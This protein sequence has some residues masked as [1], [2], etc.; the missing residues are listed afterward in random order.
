M[1]VPK[2]FDIDDTLTRAVWRFN[3]RPDLYMHDSWLTAMPEGEVLQRLLSQRTTESRLAQYMLTRLG[4]AESVFF[5]FRSPLSQ[6]ALWGGDDI[7]QLVEYIGATLYRDLVRL[8]ITREDITR[9]R[10]TVGEDLYA[11][12]QQRAPVL[13]HKVGNPPV[14]P[15]AMPLKSRM[16]L[17]GLLCLRAAFQQFPDAFWL[18]L[19]F[20]LEREWYVQ[21][22]SHARFGKRWDTITGE[23][24]V[25]VQKVAIEIKIGI[26]RDGKILFN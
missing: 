25:L 19:M 11:F 16:A 8:V 10:H 18:R 24:A 6:L 26:G 5:D 21:W 9:L 3:F 1:Q 14:F 17:A 2:T 23:C 20:K 4:V 7:R 15:G 22:K 13:T 12:M